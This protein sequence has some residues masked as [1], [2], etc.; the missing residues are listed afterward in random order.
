[1]WF[2]LHWTWSSIFTVCAGDVIHAEE[3]E[4]LDLFH[5]Y[6]YPIGGGGGVRIKKTLPV[7]PILEQKHEDIGRRDVL[8]LNATYVY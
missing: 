2:F 3:L 7:Q 5:A 6:A 1:M 8:V 4:S